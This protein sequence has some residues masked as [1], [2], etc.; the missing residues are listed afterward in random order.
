MDEN[1][2][3]LIGIIIWPLCLLLVYFLNFRL[4]NNVLNALMERIKSGAPIDFKGIVIGSIPT[5]LPKLNKDNVITKD[6]FALIHSSW[7]YPKKDKEFGRKM[8]C[9][10]V[11]L[12]AQPEV[13]DKVQYV[14]YYLH[15]TYPNPVQTRQDRSK[16]F[17]LKELAWG[18]FIMKA[19]IKI[20]DKEN[21]LEIERYINL[22]ETGSRLLL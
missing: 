20:K 16:Y 8:Y 13:L 3:N 19:E 7:R 10:Q 18:E 14:K 5:N 4:L 15:P 1:F 6:Y 22:T 9:I 2:V 21:L 11:I 17:E 12:Q